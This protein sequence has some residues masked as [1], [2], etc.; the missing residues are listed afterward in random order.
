[1]SGNICPACD[2]E[3]RLDPC[4]DCTHPLY[5]DCGRC[6]DINP[7]SLCGGSGRISDDRL[8]EYDRE[9]GVA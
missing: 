4:D 9:M 7:C 3:G 6:T 5:Y 1:M 8:A 2:G